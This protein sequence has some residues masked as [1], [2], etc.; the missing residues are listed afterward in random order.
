VFSSISS[1]FFLLLFLIFFFLLLLDSLF[2]IVSCYGIKILPS[3]NSPF[4]ITILYFLYN[5]LILTNF[6]LH[7]L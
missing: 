5:F 6:P 1:C 4:A 3:V 2:L 7:L